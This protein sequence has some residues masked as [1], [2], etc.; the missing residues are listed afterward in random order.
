MT[1]AVQASQDASI[2]I[3]HA[4]RGRNIESASRTTYFG[5]KFPCPDS[6]ASIHVPSRCMSQWSLSSSCRPARGHPAALSVVRKTFGHPGTGMRA[7]RL[8]RHAGYLCPNGTR[9]PKAHVVD[10]LGNFSQQIDVVVF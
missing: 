4:R 1:T 8:D 7:E 6:S 9:R 10:S 3:D 2:A 5:P